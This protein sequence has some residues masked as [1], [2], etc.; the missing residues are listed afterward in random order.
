MQA[1]RPP[2][3]RELLNQQQCQGRSAWVGEAP[4]ATIGTHGEPAVR[5]MDDW[6]D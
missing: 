6:I 1:R 5:I 2:H 3:L 4:K